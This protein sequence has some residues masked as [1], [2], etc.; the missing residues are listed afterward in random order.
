MT[1]SETP[2][3]PRNTEEQLV[4]NL[5][6]QPRCAVRG[7]VARGVM[8]GRVRVGGEFCGHAGDCPHKVIPN[9]KDHA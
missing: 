3:A 6:E 8:C 5:D 4:R 7:L 1:T 2:A 9:G